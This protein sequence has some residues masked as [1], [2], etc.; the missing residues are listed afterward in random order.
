[1]DEPY[2]F[3]RIAAANSLSDIYA[4]GGNPL[5]ALNV[6]AFPI[7][8]LSPD[9][10]GEILRGGAHVAQEAGCVIAGGHSVD[11]REPKYGMVVS[12][13]M[14]EASVITN[15]AST[16]GDRLVLTKPL[17]SGVLTTAIKQ[18]LATNEQRD[19]VIKVMTTLNR[20]GGEAARE[21][22][23]RAMTDVTGFGLLG[24]LA[25]MLRSGGTSAVVSMGHI[26]VLA[27]VADLIEKDV[28]PGGSK[29]NMVYVAPDVIWDP[30]LSSVSRLV[31]CDAQTSG[32][33]L[34]SVGADRVDA[35]VQALDARHALAS[36][37]IGTVTER[38]EALIRVE[39]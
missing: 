39:P 33:L 35:L 15:A 24:H 29:A 8:E 18:G 3:G 7:G 14:P 16:P 17:G 22:G 9:V 12:A 28:Y 13:I 37:V 2:D 26:P 20:S 27:G 6:V 4:M 34:M 36:A 38:G 10:L 32:G 23:V 11:D 19:R 1:V 30:G 5:I 31:L 25:E 21:V